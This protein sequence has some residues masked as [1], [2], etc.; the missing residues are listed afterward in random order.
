[1]RHINKIIV[2]CSATKAGKEFTAEDIDHWH[3]KRGFVCIGYHYV[4]R[5]DGTIEKGRDLSLPGAH[6]KG[7]NANSVGICYIG[8][9]NAAGKPSDTRTPEQ[10]KAM[11]ALIADLKRLFPGAKVHSH[12]EYAAKAC[13]CFDAAKEF[14]MIAL[15]F[16]LLMCSCSSSRKEIARQQVITEK[17]TTMLQRDT[18]Y[19]NGE[20]QA[21]SIII[22]RAETAE[23]EKPSRKIVKIYGVRSKG[24]ATKKKESEKA[25]NL[26]QT[27]LISHEQKA[28]SGKNQSR[29]IYI[30]VIISLLALAGWEYV[31][32]RKQ[33]YAV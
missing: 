9:L 26:M 3:R 7:Q 8:G 10:K 22:S 31:R 25:E 16:T 1:M 12:Y 28:I 30:F 19:I 11:R 33:L 5:L 21:D 6:C 4:I 23:A 32:H 13:P 29:A 2:H 15:L 27:S 14:A 18:I 20:M 24:T 17:S